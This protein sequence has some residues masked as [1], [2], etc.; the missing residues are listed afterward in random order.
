LHLGV[1]EANGEI[2]AAAVTAGDFRDGQR[3]PE[4][5][6]QCDAEITQVSGAGAYDTRD[7]YE[8]IDKRNAQAAIPPRRGAR[9]W[10]PGNA[11]GPPLTRDEGLRHSR[12]SGRAARKQAIGYHRRSLGETTGFRIKTIA[13]QPGAFARL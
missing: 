8:L 7:C 9:I 10:R 12:R 1:R 13:G 11:N 2:V 5:L 3:L 6:G 4:L